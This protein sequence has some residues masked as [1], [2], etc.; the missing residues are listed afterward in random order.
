MSYKSEKQRRFFHT[1]TARKQGIS[2]K[3]IEEFD[4]SSKGMDLPESSCHPG[5]SCQET[6]KKK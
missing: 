6:T 5:S 1:D 4:K 3:T 2:K